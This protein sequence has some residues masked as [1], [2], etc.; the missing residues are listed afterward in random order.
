M[1][2]NTGSSSDFEEIMYQLMELLG[3]GAYIGASLAPIIIAGIMAIIGIV[4][5][6][7]LHYIEAIPLFKIGKKLGLKN[8][9]IALIP[10]RYCSVYVLSALAGEKEISFFGKFTIKKRLYSF[11]AWLGISILGFAVVGVISGIISAIIGWIPIINLI[12]PL[13]S[14]VLN[15]LPT[16][17]CV[18]IEYYFLLDLIDVF[19]P[20]KKSNNTTAL[21]ISI[22]DAF[23]GY[24]VRGIYLWTLIKKAPLY[25]PLD[26]V[27]A[28]N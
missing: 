5:S 18:I 28:D 20:D 11:L 7:A 13:I 17:A 19:N 23:I 1:F 3:L 25:N 22:I 8:A 14:F 15:L 4:V 12:V 27:S 9:W 16:A 26:R 10:I 6:L 24:I 21:V 2:Y